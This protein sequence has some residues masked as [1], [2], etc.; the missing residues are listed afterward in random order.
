[1]RLLSVGLIFL[2]GFYCAT[3]FAQL[4]IVLD[5]TNLVQNTTSA[6]NSVQLLKNQ[7]TNLQNF[8]SD[9]TW[10]DISPILNQLASEIQKG[11]ALAYSAKNMDQ[12]FHNKFPG[13][14]P[15]TDYDTEYQ[16]WSETTMDTIR[17]VLASAGIQ[18]NA[19]GDEQNTLDTLKSLNDTSVGRMQAIQVGNKIAAEQVG[20]MQK[21]RQLII[22]QTNAQNAYMAYNV[23]KEQAQE[24]A[25][26]NL[27][28][29]P[30][31]YPKYGTG[32]GFGADNLPHINH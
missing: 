8:N 4:S 3:S 19:F 1:M 12:V 10:S 18:S 13:Y 11:N 14:K 17:N 30:I 6:V 24:A 26:H 7:L 32:Q 20:Q 22:S 15:Q 2:C 9:P 23:Q 25:T 28:N 29:H 31:D 5:P 21:L 16:N 27:L